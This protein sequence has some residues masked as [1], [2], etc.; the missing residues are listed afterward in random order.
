MSDTAQAEFFLLRS[1]GDVMASV[2]LERE[3]SGS[4]GPD[5]SR[6]QV[7]EWSRAHDRQAAHLPATTIRQNTYPVQRT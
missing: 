2:G 5:E 4:A 3:R 6:L 7:V 1:Q